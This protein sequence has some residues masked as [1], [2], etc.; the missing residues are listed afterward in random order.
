MKNIILTLIFCSQLNL[1]AHASDISTTSHSAIVDSTAVTVISPL[2]RVA[3]LEL[4]TSEG[5]SSCPPADRFLNNLKKEGISD[6][7]II[8]LAFHVTYWDYIGWKDRF[9]KPQY[10]ARQRELAH[11]NKQK[12]VYTPQFVLAGDDFRRYAHFSDEVNKLVASKAQVS[13]SLTIDTQVVD[14]PVINNQSINSRPEELHI[15]LTSDISAAEVKDVALYIA[16]VENNLNS[17]VSDGENEG[18][19]MQHNYVVRQLSAPYLQSKSVSN[20]EREHIIPLDPEW[21]KQ[22]LSI[23]AFA[24]NPDTGEILQAVK[25]RY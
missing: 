20:L 24:E 22:D 1:L 15:R 7:Q 18:E 10:D 13:L 4:Y 25:Y 6:K 14:G 16:V 19:K 21:K 23:V 12:T 11:K 9:A 3:L 17:D 2:H 5:C 8:P